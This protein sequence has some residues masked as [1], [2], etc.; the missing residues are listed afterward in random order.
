M[1]VVVQELK[2][3]LGKLDST[4]DQNTAML[5]RV[6]EQLKMFKEKVEKL[7]EDVVDVKRHVD[8]VRTLYKI[9]I[10]LLTASAGLAT[11]FKAV[12]IKFF[13]LPS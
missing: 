10:M 9:T 1:E 6:E 12:L 3:Y 13:P 8:T 7:E 4:L 5:I 11:I 2:S